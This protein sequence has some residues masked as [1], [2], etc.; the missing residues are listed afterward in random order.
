MNPKSCWLRSPASCWWPP[1]RCL[2]AP[3]AGLGGAPTSRRRCQAAARGST[4]ADYG[5]T[6]ASPHR[7][8]GTAHRTTHAAT[9]RHRAN[10]SMPA[11][12]SGS[13][14]PPASSGCSPA[15]SVS[16]EV[17]SSFQ[18]W[19]WRWAS[20]CRSPSGPRCSSFGQQRQPPYAGPAGHSRPS[21]LAAARH[22]HCRRHCWFIRGHRV[23]SRVDAGKLT[24]AFTGLLVLVAGY[25]AARSIPHLI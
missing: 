2:A 11:E 23:A 16:A 7:R 25:T 22:L 1:R 17:S 3:T 6:R 12:P 8:P 5:D 10:G 14:S 24:V 15:S 20:T 9:C 19:Y 21:R 13:F 4:R 18:R